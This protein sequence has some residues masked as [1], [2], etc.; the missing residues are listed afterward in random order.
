ML[1]SLSL[2]NF[3]CF[4]KLDIEFS[5]LNIF[6]GINSM[7]KST[8]IQA[9]LLLKQSYDVMAISK[10][11][12]LNGDLV[13]IGVGSDLLFNGSKID[14]IE[15]ILSINNKNMS[16][17]YDYSKSSDYLSL[18]DSYIEQECQLDMFNLFQQSFTYVSADRIAPKRIYEKAYHKVHEMNQVGYNGELAADYLIER[19]NIDKINNK[20]VLHPKNKSLLL[21][22]HTEEWINEISP[23]IRLRTKNYEEAGM[24]ALEYVSKDEAQSAFNPLNVGFGLSYVLPIIVALLKAKSGDLVILENPEA[25]LHPKGQRKMGE[26]IAKAA[27]GGVQII[28]ETHSDHLLNGVRVAVKKNDIDPKQIRL[29]Y[30]YRTSEGIYR[31]SCPVILADGNLSSWPDGFFDEWDKAIDELFFRW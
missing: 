9:L 3:K 1:N 8:S 21:I 10:G 14:I 29:N 2:K 27:V 17:T 24:V 18:K 30:F 5:N 25:H 20:N 26:L 7:G 23:G 6:A 16:W 13:N 15:I 11:L 12:Y 19:G 4:E 28:V 31:K 22:D